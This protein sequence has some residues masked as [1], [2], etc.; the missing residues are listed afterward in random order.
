MPDLAWFAFFA[1][2]IVAFI[3]LEGKR[4]EKKYGKASNSPDLLGVSMLE[5]Q[6]LLQPDRQ[7]SQLQQQIKGEWVMVETDEESDNKT[8]RQR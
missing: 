6:K 7:V 3:V 1:L 5:T 8:R 4:Q 2:L